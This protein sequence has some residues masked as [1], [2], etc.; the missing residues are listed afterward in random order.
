MIASVE[1]LRDG[2]G[3][4]V[5]DQISSSKLFA[6]ATAAV[7]GGTSQTILPGGQSN[8]SMSQPTTVPKCFTNEPLVPTVFVVCPDFVVVSPVVACLL[9]AGR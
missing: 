5:R 6:A 3:G 8:V 7:N 9:F 1:N 4:G 2:G